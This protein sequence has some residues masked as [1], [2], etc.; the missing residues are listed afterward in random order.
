M[1]LQSC[2][3]ALCTPIQ[4]LL[5]LSS[6]HQLNEMLPRLHAGKEAGPMGARP[7][8]AHPLTQ[9]RVLLAMGAQHSVL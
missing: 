9:G 8:Q 7:P 3:V 5:Q 1:R 6:D 2:V 4:A